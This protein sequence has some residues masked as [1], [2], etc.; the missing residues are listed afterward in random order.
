MSEIK[1]KKVLLKLSGELLMGNH[2]FGVSRDAVRAVMDEIRGIVDLGVKVAIVIG[3]GNI[4]RGVS[5]VLAGLT[6]RVT[7]DYMGM[8]ATVM[9]ALALNEACNL[10]G[11]PAKIQSALSTQSMVEM[12]ARSTALQYL[13]EGKLLIFAGGTGSPFFTT[14]TAAALRALEMNCDILLKATKV[15]GVYTDDPN[16]NPHAV[17]YASITFDEAINQ[18]LKIMDTTA[19]TLCREHKLDIVVFE[20]TR[21]HTLN[22]IILGNLSEGTLI[23]C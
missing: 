8:L 6:D 15:D 14:D 18:R 23:H 9:N 12:Y 17:K 21:R 11:V 19:L 5:G 2:A 20:M 4:F 1:Y 3:G 7:A 16:N 10:V 13:E 22:N